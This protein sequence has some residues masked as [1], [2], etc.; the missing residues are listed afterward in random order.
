MNYRLFVLLVVIASSYIAIGQAEEF[1]VFPAQHHVEIHKPASLKQK[2]Y[3]EPSQIYFSNNQI[4]V[5][6]TKG[7]IQIKGIK[8]D[9]VGIY[10]QAA[11][12]Q[13]WYCNN[14]INGKV[15]GHYNT[16]SYFCEN[17]GK[18]PLKKKPITEKN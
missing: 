12:P 14:I 18:E 2:I 5:Q 9:D 8:S 3:V 10:Y 11:H 16:Y 6:S 4:F 15:C 13:S 1:D 17:C 7:M